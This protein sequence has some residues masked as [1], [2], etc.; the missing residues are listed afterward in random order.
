MLP[1][2]RRSPNIWDH[3]ELYE[4]QN[5]AI[6]PGGAI[7]QAMAAVHDWA[8][9]CV[10]DVGCGS[11]F[12]LPRFADRA[13]EVVGVEPHAPLVTLA[14]RRLASLP[15]D[16]SSRVEVRHGSAEGLP[17]PDGSID[18]AHARWAYF[19]GP[20]CEP[21]LAELDRVIRPGGTAFVIDYDPT[22]S[23]F[24]R[25]FTTAWPRHDAV[26]VER[27][28]AR[29][30]WTTS[31]LDVRWEFDDE[32]TLAAVLGIEFPPAVAASAMA[33]LARSAEESSTSL[34]CSVALRHHTW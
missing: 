15:S 18:V 25:W 1:G 16:V 13:A 23:Q 30:G 17:V 19:F 21:G 9:T 22:R 6:D 33:E 8:G 3:P 10:L 12:H 28:W 26:A 20:G 5:L 34:A 11:G 2:V 7:E 24:G 27:F 29:R 32:A 4:R 14:R 31:S